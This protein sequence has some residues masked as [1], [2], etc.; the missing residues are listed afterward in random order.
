[1]N[2]R[3]EIRPDL[4]KET[5]DTDIKSLKKAARQSIGPELEKRLQ[6]IID[7]GL[8]DLQDDFKIY[9]NNAIAKLTLVTII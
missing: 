1:M 9:W 4:K 5:L 3:T 7:T 6:T 2:K 8:V